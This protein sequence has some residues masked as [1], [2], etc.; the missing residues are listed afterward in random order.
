MY[1]PFYFNFEWMKLAD[2]DAQNEGA[3]RARIAG[4]P[5][6][7]IGSQSG[8]EPDSRRRAVRVNRPERRVVGYS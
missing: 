2:I 7:I 6:N 8:E 1:S 5:K 4:N 3:Y